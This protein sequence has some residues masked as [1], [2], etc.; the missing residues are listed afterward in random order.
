[1]CQHESEMRRLCRFA[2]LPQPVLDLLTSHY[3][4]P[5]GELAP[6]YGGFSHH[7]ALATIA[8]RRCVVK[9]A[10]S[11]AKRADLR[12]EAGVLE[13]LRGSGLPAPALLALA[14]DAIWT[15]EVLEFVPGDNGLHILASQPAALDLVYGALGHTLAAVH[16]LAL[17]PPAQDMLLAERTRR[18]QAALAGLPI[19]DGLRAALAAGL[20]QA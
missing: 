20:D 13:L 10:E 5:P 1:M 8:G 19:E 2:M 15:V 17:A 14:E 4:A 16:S 18:L 9:A 12:H 6:T 3:G 7:S 11:A